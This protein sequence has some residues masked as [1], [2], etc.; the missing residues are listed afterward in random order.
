[1]GCGFYIATGKGEGG[2]V[3]GGLLPLIDGKGLAVPVLY[4]FALNPTVEADGNSEGPHVWVMSRLSGGGYLPCEGG[5][6][7]AEFHW[8]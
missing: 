2:R 6:D 3:D 5:S 7:V 8:L 4:V 1:M